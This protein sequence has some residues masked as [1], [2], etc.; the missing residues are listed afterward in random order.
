VDT[1]TAPN[2]CKRMNVQRGRFYQRKRP[3]SSSQLLVSSWHGV[4]QH[5]ADLHD[6][7]LKQVQH[8]IVY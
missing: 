4:E 7:V 2:A 5:G 8:D 3:D 1:G 6:G